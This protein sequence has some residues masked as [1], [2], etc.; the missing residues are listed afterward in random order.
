M[1][2]SG[3]V[4]FDLPFQIEN[5]NIPEYYT[6]LSVD[7]TNIDKKGNKIILNNPEFNK[8]DILNKINN[9]ND[10]KVFINENEL[11][12]NEFEIEF[13]SNNITISDKTKIRR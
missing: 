1:H 7:K 2:F 4:S 12:Y 5:K 13:N 11:D 9:V 8:E 10:V 3:T 6:L